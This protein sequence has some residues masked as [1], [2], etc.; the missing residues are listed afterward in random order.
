M[1]EPFIPGILRVFVFT[2]AF[3]LLTW[4]L[5]ELRGWNFSWLPLGL[6]SVLYLH[7]LLV[8]LI[9]G[10]L[11]ILFSKFLNEAHRLIQDQPARPSTILIKDFVRTFYSASYFWMGVIAYL[12]VGIGLISYHNLKPAIP[13]INGNLYDDLL[14]H[15]DQ[16]LSVGNWISVLENPTVTYF[17][18]QVYFQMWTLGGIS[19]AASA[20]KPVLFWRFVATWALAYGLSMPISILFPA[21]GP[22]FSHPNLFGHITA[23]HSAD[24]MSRLWNHY[25]AFQSDP[26]QTPIVKANGIV[27][28]PSLHI[29]IV[30]LSVFFLGKVVPQFKGILWTFLGLFIISTVYLGWHYLLDGLAGVLLGWV[31]LRISIRWFPDESSNR[32]VADKMRLIPSRT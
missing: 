17:L 12:S 2:S 15:W 1:V 8:Y 25:L 31:V 9:V 28:M 18:D 11:V 13:L 20:S 29:T 3:A 27:A 23:T 21:L 30:F 22:A 10:P 24:V 6:P 7:F 16:Q 14:L 32:K 26:L 19:L 4:S 5:F